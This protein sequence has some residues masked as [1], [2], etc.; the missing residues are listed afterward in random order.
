MEKLGDVM[1][2]AV[3]RYEVAK[4]PDRFAIKESV[5]GSLF[6]G[7]GAA[8][9]RRAPLVHLY[10]YAARRGSFDQGGERYAW[11]AWR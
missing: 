8:S 9:N 6:R 3:G 2:H 5:Y 11:C 1:P 4:P 10:R 7:T